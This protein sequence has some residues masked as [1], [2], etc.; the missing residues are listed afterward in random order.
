MTEVVEVETAVR[1]RQSIICQNK[2]SDEKGSK[3]N[4]A[5]LLTSLPQLRDLRGGPTS[6]VRRKLRGHGALDRTKTRRSS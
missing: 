3:F 5:Y 2:E 6:S 4:D 1:I